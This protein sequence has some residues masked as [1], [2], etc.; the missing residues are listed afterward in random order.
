MSLTLSD[1]TSKKAEQSVGG[2]GMACM[3]QQLSGVTVRWSPLLPIPWRLTMTQ[4]QQQRRRHVGVVCSVALQN[5]KNKE[6]MKLKELFEEAYERCRTSPMDG[7]SF[8]LQQFNEALDKYDFNA[9]VGTKASSFP[10]L[11]TLS[12]VLDFHVGFFVFFE[13]HTFFS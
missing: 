10:K 7:V 12:L 9:E 2:K 1:R 6:R 13:F 3:A 8:T 5:A 4:K 11:S